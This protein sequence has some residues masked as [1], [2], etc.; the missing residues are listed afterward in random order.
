MTN[1]VNMEINA[2]IFVRFETID[3]CFGLE[4]VGEIIDALVLFYIIPLMKKIQRFL[5]FPQ[6]L[7]SGK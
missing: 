5:S 2:C 7:T 6:F 3:K 1:E 4:T